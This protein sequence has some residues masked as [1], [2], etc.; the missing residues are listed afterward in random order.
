MSNGAERQQ[1]AFSLLWPSGRRPPQ[2]EAVLSA[3]AARDIGLTAVIRAMASGEEQRKILEQVL[4]HPTLEGATIR[5]RQ[6]ILADLLR[7]P[8][9]VECLQVLLPTL[10]ALAFDYYHREAHESATLFEVIWRLGELEGI[11]ECVTALDNAFASLGDEVQ[12]AGLRALR[13]EIRKIATDT[14]FQELVAE[15]PGLLRKVRASQSVTIGVN[16]DHHLQPIEAT[17]LAVNEKRFSEGTFLS[18]LLDRNGEQWHGIAPLH[19]NMPA[20][21]GMMIGVAVPLPAPPKTTPMMTQLFRDLA[22]V[23]NK[24]CE[25]VAQA[26]EAY[27]TVSGQ[28]FVSLYRDMIF[29]LAGVQLVKRLQRAG[30]P[31]CRPELAPHEERI[32]Q[33]ADNYNVALALSKLFG[34]EEIDLRREIVTNPVFI[35]SEGRIQILTGPNRGGKTTYMQAVGLTQTLAQAGLFVPG[36][37]ARISP[38]DGIYTHFPVEEKLERGTGRFGDEARRLKEIFVRATRHSLILLNESLTS[39]SHGESLYL[40]RDLIR[41]MRRMGVRALFTTHM[42][43]LATDLDRLNEDTRGDSKVV[44]IVASRIDDQTPSAEV[45]TEGAIVRSYQIRPG[46]PMG[47]SFAR[48]LALRYGISHEQLVTSLQARGVLDETGN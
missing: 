27:N 46:P 14:L 39:T 45:G 1:P 47:R 16:L 24:V 43:E 2:Q 12:A 37:T 4:L 33:I 7:F 9:L 48:E 38:A 8:L 10:E 19:T 11:T 13:A 23:L 35:G 31:M 5:Y 40:A 20:E 15:L 21:A 34:D 28:L 41:V 44:S 22:R 25:P 26:L 42:H 3:E 17:L 6:D 29:Y 30:L 18:R 32:C 36:A